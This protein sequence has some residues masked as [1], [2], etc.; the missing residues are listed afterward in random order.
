MG[1][2]RIKIHREKLYEMVWE[3]PMTVL[4]REYGLSDVGLRKI[5]K[6]MYIPLP[7]QGYHLRTSKGKKAPLPPAG[8][9][10]V[11]YELYVS[12]LITVEGVKSAKGMQEVDFEKNP[13][14]KII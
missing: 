1:S 6:R 7:P 10:E 12:K 9:H 14:N 13:A 11:V 5:C 2:E 8:N 3:K 4:A